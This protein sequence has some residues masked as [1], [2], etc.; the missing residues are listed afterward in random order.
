MARR[1]SRKSMKQDEFIEAAFDAGAWIEKHWRTVAAGVGAALAL[2]LIVVAWSWWSGRRSDEVER[3]LSEGLYLYSGPEDTSGAAAK[4]PSGG[5]RY[6]EA[7]PLF[8]KAARLGANSARGRV[9]EFYQGASLL[10]LG[11][12]AEATPILEEVAGTAQDRP[13]ADAAR[14]M[15]AEAYAKAGDVD[16]AAAAYRKLAEEPGAAFPPDFALLQLSRVLDDHG[17]GQEARLVLQE[18]VTK[19]PQGSAATEARTRLEPK[20]SGQ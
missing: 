11:R 7:L 19:Y 14:G 18:I 8:E 5:G 2:I 3:L 12:T 15:T 17:K 9:A 16:K 10:R 6:A 1:I 4:A 13:L 20:K